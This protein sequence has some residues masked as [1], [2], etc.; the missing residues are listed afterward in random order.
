MTRSAPGENKVPHD[1]DTRRARNRKR[2][3]VRIVRSV[4]LSGERQFHQWLRDLWLADGRRC[5]GRF[6]GRRWFNRPRQPFVPLPPRTCGRCGRKLLAPIRA[7]KRG[8][9][10][11]AIIAVLALRAGPEPMMMTRAC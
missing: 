6:D 4:R 7:G 11:A 8:M 5:C 2:A 10:G 3:I 9:E 1:E